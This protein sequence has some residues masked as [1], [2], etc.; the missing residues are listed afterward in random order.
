[1]RYGKR[2]LILKDMTGSKE[3]KTSDDRVPIVA[4]TTTPS[5]NITTRAE[6]KIP[7]KRGGN[8]DKLKNIEIKQPQSVSDERKSKLKFIEI[9][10]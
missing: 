2:T 8:I 6:P 7:T 4:K 9:N 10:L 3:T 1:M 5:S